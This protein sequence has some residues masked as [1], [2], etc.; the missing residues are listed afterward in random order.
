MKVSG[1]SV[2]ASC[3][4]GEESIGNIP[5]WVVGFWV[6]ENGAME[7]SGGAVKTNEGDQSCQSF[8]YGQNVIVTGGIFDESVSGFVVDGCKEMENTDSTTKAAYPYRVRQVIAT[9]TISDATTNYYELEP[10]VTKANEGT[11]A[12]PATLKLMANATGNITIDSGKVATIDLNGHVL[13]GNGSGSVITNSGTLNIT[14]S[15]KTSNH[16]FK[17][18]GANGMYWDLDTTATS[19]TDY[20]T[21]TARPAANDIVLV[22]GGV[23][24]GGTGTTQVNSGHNDSDGGG[25]FNNGT[26]NLKAGTVVGNRTAGNDRNGTGGGIYNENGKTFTMGAG[27]AVIG[28]TATTS[29]TDGNF[30][31]GGIYNFG[32][33]QM[34]GG[35]VAFNT[36]SKNDGT[37]TNTARGGGIYNSCYAGGDS[38]SYYFKMVSGTVK[39][40]YAGTGGA[41]CGENSSITIGDGCRISS[42]KAFEGGGGMAV[43]SLTAPQRIQRLKSLLRRLSVKGRPA[44]AKRPPFPPPSW[45][46][47]RFLQIIFIAEVN[48]ST[49]AV[50][51]KGAGRSRHRTPHL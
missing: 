46:M 41:I 24:T 23:I 40:N 48:T 30:Y 31:G 49:G 20:T 11:S 50:T 5:P 29:G 27:A 21:L 39:Y 28:N 44:R 3:G 18:S 35:T 2:E 13:K 51:I 43:S 42:N 15:D 17:V 25:I 19:G 1:G 6:T 36:A 47:K 45:E 10:A 8:N 7:V 38:S 37:I 4:G 22:K 26:L 32:A 12:L 16:Y 34:E 14:D 9:V 33:F